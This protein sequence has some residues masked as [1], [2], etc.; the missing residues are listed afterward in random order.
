M[1]IKPLSIGLAAL[2]IAGTLLTSAVTADAREGRHGAFA[3]GAAVGAV[4]G[5]VVGSQLY[6]PRYGYAEP[7]YCHVEHRRVYLDNGDVI[8]RRVRVC[9]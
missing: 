3:A 7:A 5:A 6:G 9:D 8:I 1:T 4:G 2:G